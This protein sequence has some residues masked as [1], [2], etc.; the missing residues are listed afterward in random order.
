MHT[1]VVSVFLYTHATRLLH[2]MQAL[3]IHATVELAARR[4]GVF[5][6]IFLLNGSDMRQQ[7]G[8]IKAV[9]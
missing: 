4:S 3:N 9:S 5:S 8:Q 1:A 2:P 6:A 7:S